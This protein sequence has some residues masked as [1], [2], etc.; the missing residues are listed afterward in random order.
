VFSKLAGINIDCK[1][2]QAIIAYNFLHV[3]C[4]TREATPVS[5]GVFLC[6]GFF[7]ILRINVRRAQ[8][9]AGGK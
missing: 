1:S 9:A 8:M 5:T 3:F 2:I 6:K 4:I 7:Y